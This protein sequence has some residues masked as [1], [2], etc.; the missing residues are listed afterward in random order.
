MPDFNR[1]S[2]FVVLLKVPHIFLPHNHCLSTPWDG[3][4]MLDSLFQCIALEI[5]SYQHSTVK[6][7]KYFDGVKLSF[8]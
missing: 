6:L 1:L 2:Q 5:A 7:S 8:H 4:V 3:S